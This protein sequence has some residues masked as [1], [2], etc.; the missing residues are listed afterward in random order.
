MIV[1]TNL[2]ILLC[3]LLIGTALRAQNQPLPPDPGPANPQAAQAAEAQR[4]AM[5]RAAFAASTNAIAPAATP[6]VG[7]PSPQPVPYVPGGRPPPP[8]GRPYDPNSIAV[9]TTPPPFDPNAPPGALPPG[10][11]PPGGIPPNYVAVPPSAAAS[12]STMDQIIDVGTIKFKGVDVNQVLD[13]YADLVNKTILRPATLAGAPVWLTTQTPLT[14]REVIQALDTVLGMS[15]IAMMNFGDKFMKADTTAT[16]INAGMPFS[17]LNASQLPDFGSYVTHV[18]QLQHALPSQVMPLLTPFSK[19]P[20]AVTAIDSTGMLVLRD[21]TENVKRMLEMIHEIDK[22]I[23]ADYDQLVLPIKYA[24]ASEIAAALN[25]L[26]SGGGGATTLGGGGGGATGGRSAMGRTGATGGIGSRPGMNST[27][28]G[29]NPM[30]FNQPGQ[31]TQPQQPASFTDRL[32]NVIKKINSQGEFQILGQTKMIADERTN[33]LLIFASREDMK[34]ITNIVS[35]LDVVLAQ[36]LIET[37]IIS[38]SLDKGHNLGFSYVQH[39]QS[40]GN[41][42]AVG[43]GGGGKNFFTPSSFLNSGTSNSASA[44]SGGPR[45]ECRSGEARQQFQNPAAA[46]HPDLA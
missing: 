37:A 3:L 6:G 32:S 35:K 15:G 4:K 30:G 10:A 41:F 25:S 9:P 45:R 1:K 36:V 39:P 34:M 44:L 2:L 43:A 22:E 46:A 23:P 24:K 16:A 11:L 17:R 33:S 14:K 18:V 20:N 7:V 26:S 8:G 38:V 19:I 28:P 31:P 29:Q 5:A 42:S 12:N 27:Y 13:V 21:F 40:S